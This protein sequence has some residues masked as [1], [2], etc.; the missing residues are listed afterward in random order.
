MLMRLI[1]YNIRFGGQGREILLAKTLHTIKPD[2]VILQEATNPH[3]VERLA[4]ELG[5]SF[6]VAR[7]GCSLALLS[8]LPIIHHNWHYTKW[9]KH[10]FLE[11]VCCGP[12]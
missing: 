10:P 9:L 5:M 8:H 11:A 4:R 2:L 6:W 7:K 3:V 1:S 12:N